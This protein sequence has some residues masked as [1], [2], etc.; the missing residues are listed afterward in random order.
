VTADQLYYVFA[1]TEDVT[2]TVEST[3][4]FA[5]KPL[6]YTFTAAPNP[7]D[8]H[9]TPVTV[10]VTD[11]NL[12]TGSTGARLYVCPTNAWGDKCQNKDGTFTDADTN[13][14]FTFQTNDF[15]DLKTEAKLYLR[16]THKDS[17]RDKV[18][19]TFTELEITQ[20][21]VAPLKYT[22]TVDKQDV[23]AKDEVIL[24]TVTIPADKTASL[25]AGLTACKQA[26]WAADTATCDKREDLDWETT[27]ASNEPTTQHLKF[28]FNTIDSMK[29]ESK[30]W[31]FVHEP[32]YSFAVDEETG[33]QAVTYTAPET[34]YTVKTVEGAL[35]C[36]SN[37]T[38]QEVTVTLDETK[39]LPEG[40]KVYLAGC[41]A[42]AFKEDATC[43]HGEFDYKADDH[44]AKFD[45]K[46]A[47]AVETDSCPAKMYFFAGPDKA[48][49]GSKTGGKD[50]PVT[51]LPKPDAASSVVVPL[52][53]ALL[54]LIALF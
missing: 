34:T 41:I 23:T 32:G 38:A 48:S 47:L 54:S 9:T 15:G 7:A 17:T 13:K 19:A 18:D 8:T 40:N 2:P 52:F 51:K 11:A 1:E 43:V 37:D 53:V 44:T 30:L 33:S 31:F 3:V 16:V 27:S 42:D 26:K 49:L 46:A 45:P 10:T 21:Y 25:K 6:V 24:A 14:S 39:K 29:G 28:S 4:T 20:P 12:P 5:P 50:H 36:K 22:F 35:F